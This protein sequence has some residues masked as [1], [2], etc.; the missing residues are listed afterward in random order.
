MHPPR[1]HITTRQRLRQFPDLGCS[2]S[3]DQRHP[4][5]EKCLWW[6]PGQT[7]EPG[8]CSQRHSWKPDHLQRQFNATVKKVKVRFFIQNQ[9]Q[10]G[11]HHQNTVQR[12]RRIF[13][14]HQKDVLNL[15]QGDQQV[16]Q[17]FK[18]LDRTQNI[19]FGLQAGK[20]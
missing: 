11:Q 20:R 19:V 7:S 14:I 18:C 4:N 10:R 8:R 3:K 13:K 9:S 15:T 16:G 17:Q 5:K 2:L 12:Q 1:L 6:M